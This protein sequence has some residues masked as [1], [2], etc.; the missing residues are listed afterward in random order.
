MIA[1]I[2][3]VI[4]SLAGGLTALMKIYKIGPFMTIGPFPTQDDPIPEPEP[5]A[6][7]APVSSPT[8]APTPMID[9]LCAGIRDYEGAPGDLNYQLNNPGDCR[10][11]PVGYL[12]KYGDVITIDTDTDP[13]Y[14]FHKGKFSKFPTYAQGWEYLQNLFLN[15]ATLHPSWTLLELMQNYSPSSDGNAPAAY[16]AFLAKR[17]NVSVS[18]TLQDLFNPS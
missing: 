3:L 10:P 8:A 14:P 9:T 1:I 5:I 6:P 15:W 17:C 18:I 16:A 4:A 12:P 13:A 2:G 11:S 7:P